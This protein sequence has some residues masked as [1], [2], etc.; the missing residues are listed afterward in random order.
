MILVSAF[1]AVFQLPSYILYLI[2]NV[3]PNLAYAQIGYFTTLFITFL[4]ICTNPFIYA[5]KFDPVKQILLRLIPCNRICEQDNETFEL[6]EL[7][8]L[9]HEMFDG[10]VTDSN[11]ILTERGRDLSVQ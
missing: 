2:L 4:Y 6:P 11:S 7:P 8:L 9:Y 3:N 5:T 1:F 10:H